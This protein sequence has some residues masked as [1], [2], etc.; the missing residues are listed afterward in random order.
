MSDLAWS[1]GVQ[2]RVY[3]PGDSEDK[4]AAAIKDFNEFV[5]K[6]ERVEVIAL[7]FRDGVNIV[8]RRYSLLMCQVCM[9]LCDKPLETSVPNFVQV[10]VFTCVFPHPGSHLGTYLICHNCV[11]NW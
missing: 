11:R 7:P 2:G 5:I 6:D 9:C 1:L 3:A 8:Q 4:M 10:C